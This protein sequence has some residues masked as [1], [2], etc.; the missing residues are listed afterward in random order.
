MTNIL[1]TFAGGKLILALEGGYNN[2]ITADC[3]IECINVL[4]GNPCKPLTKTQYFNHEKTLL[5]IQKIIDIHSKYW[6]YLVPLKIEQKIEKVEKIEIKNKNVE[7][8]EKKLDDL[9]IE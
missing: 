3:A 1:K 5:Q 7:T 8:I 6:K 4:L 9:K 2:Q